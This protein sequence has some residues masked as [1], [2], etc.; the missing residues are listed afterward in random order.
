MSCYQSGIS[1]D[2]SA[3]AGAQWLMLQHQGRFYS[4]DLIWANMRQKQEAA[5]E[6]G[7]S[8]RCKARPLL[9]V[10]RH[11]PARADHNHWPGDT[12]HT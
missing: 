10:V 4:N 3:V 6:P 12:P 11:G 2:T 8:F 1:T 5:A 7:I 9:P